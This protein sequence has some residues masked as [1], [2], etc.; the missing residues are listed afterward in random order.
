MLRDLGMLRYR[1]YDKLQEQLDVWINV[2][3]NKLQLVG[4]VASVYCP[5]DL[6]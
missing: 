2:K 4:I 1:R 3:G 6:D 5:S